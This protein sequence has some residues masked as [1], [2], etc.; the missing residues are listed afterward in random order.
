M[1]AEKARLFG[2][3]EMLES[4]LKAKHPKE[5]K[6]FGRAVQNFDKDIWDK[7]CYSIVKRASLAKFS[8]NPKLNDYL[9]STKNRILV[10]ASPRDRIWGIG[11]GQSI[12]MRRI[13]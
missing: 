2:D 6:A 9:N 10:E 11:M 8:Q 5:M 1:M 12:R 4:I 7:E 3:D 13:P